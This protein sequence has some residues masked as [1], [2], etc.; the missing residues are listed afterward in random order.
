MINL[1]NI[2]ELNS[3]NGNW[4][5]KTG[6]FMSYRSN[7]HIK[8]VPKLVTVPLILIAVWYIIYGLNL[9]SS[10]LF[11]PPHKVLLTTWDLIVSGDVFVHV[12]V[13]L[14]RVA[15]GY[16]LAMAL[17]IPLGLLAGWFHKIDDLIDVTMNAVRSTPVVAWIPMSILWFGMG[18][19]ACVFII[20]MAVFF[21]TLLNTIAGVRQA[22]TKL[23]EAAVTLGVPRNSWCMFREVILPS[24]TPLIITGMKLSLGYAWAA[25]V[26]AEMISQRS[27]LGYLL[28]SGKISLRMDV[29][30][31]AMLLIMIC[32]LLIGRPIN[33]LERRILKWHVSYDD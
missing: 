30:F 24:A 27:G 22:D 3:P 10:V 17:A 8:F 13:S 29:V 5:N 32:G 2:L 23:I 28:M 1:S 4:L 15:M 21:P 33:F 20:F 12:G 26:A 9:F 14:L 7:D 11:P 31:S 19:A 18:Q 6:A 16:I 25:I